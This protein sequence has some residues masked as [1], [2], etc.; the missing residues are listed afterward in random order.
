M[1]YT[2]KAKDKSTKARRGELQLAHGVVQTPV[3][4]PVGTVGTVKGLTNE[5]LIALGAEI[6]LG[7]TY[8]L[9][10]RPT[11]EYIKEYFGSLHGFSGWPK[12]IL[13]DSGGFQ[14]F[15]LGLK[16]EGQGSDASN[17]SLVKI[18]EEG[19]A[20][21]S[22]I[23]GSKHMF[24]PER[25][26][27]IQHNLGSDIMM[28]L[29]MCPDGNASYDDI[30]RA[31]DQTH[32]WAKRGIDYWNSIKG[33]SQQN[34]FGIVQG[35]PH[36]D[37]RQQSA[38]YISSLG[39]DGIAIGGVANGGESKAKMHEAVDY[40]I[41]FIPEDKPRYLMGVGEPVDMVRAVSQGIDMFDCVLP[42]RLGRH[43]VAW[44]GNEREGFSSLNLVRPHFRNDTSVLDPDC[45]CPTCANGYSRAYIHHLMKEKELLG[46][47]LIT[48][49]NL[50]HV[51]NLFQRM[52]TSIE[53]VRFD[54]DF[55]NVLPIESS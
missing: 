46:I 35:G 29:D 16:L 31:V 14:V 25:V 47:R 53:A 10:L 19:A 45:T 44:V 38:E 7:N 6:I 42:T 34:Y 33:D 1:K 39:F 32:R 30:K 50:A 4:M 21:R 2:F 9:H 13:T 12:P 15:S 24:T 36:A 17:P 3:F 49:H 37:L 41:P 40:A 55:A 26:V 11:S 20:F 27:D 43:G 8:H 54:K 5:E 52:R 28:P 22:H 48:Q 18:T 51:I 23:D